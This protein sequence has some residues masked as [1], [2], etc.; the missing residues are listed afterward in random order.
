MTG[1]A[2]GRPAMTAARVFQG[3][4]GT[5]YR[6]DAMLALRADHAA[7]RDAVRASLDL[8]APSLAPLV[9]QFGIVE[10]GTRARSRAEYL[11]RPDLGRSLSP[12]SRQT[13]RDAGDHGR[14]V[15]ILLGDGLSAQAVAAQA[16]AL[17]PALARACAERGWSVGR[18]FVV[19]HCR[20]GVMNDVGELLDPGVVVLLI[21]ERPGLA[22]AAALS[23]YLAF[24]PRPGDTDARRNLVA[25]IHRDGL[26][27]A[28]ATERIVGLIAAIQAASASGTLITEP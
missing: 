16:P 20:V 12:Q 28:A 17:L 14:D 6:T 10:L 3:R 4:V 24:R 15:Q 11:R 5:S 22:T 23:A 27:T 18:P 25:S 1:L 26:G 13:L 9:D 2:P 21:G 19:R 7:A 8:D